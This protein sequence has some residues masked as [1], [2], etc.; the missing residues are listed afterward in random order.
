MLFH[1]LLA[2]GGDT[3]AELGDWNASLSTITTE[4]G[5]VANGAVVS[6]IADLSTANVAI[7]AGSGDRPVI[8]RTKVPGLRLIAFDSDDRLSGAVTATVRTAVILFYL[9]ASPAARTLLSRDTSATTTKPAF[10]IGLTA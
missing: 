10:N 1:I 2:A 3:S 6:S 5:D 8:D 4:T 9:P 7:S